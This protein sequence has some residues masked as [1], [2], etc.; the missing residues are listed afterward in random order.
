VKK[1][2]INV[3]DEAMKAFAISCLQKEGVDLAQVEFSFIQLT[4]HGVVIMALHF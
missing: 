3:N 4:M 2:R 1:V